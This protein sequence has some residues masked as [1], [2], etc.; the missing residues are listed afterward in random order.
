MPSLAQMVAGSALLAISWRMVGTLFA[1]ALHESCWDAGT[2]AN[3]SKA[4][5]KQ[6]KLFK[7]MKQRGKGAI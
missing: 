3:Q 1:N 7:K 2:T 4:K 6:S 5:Q